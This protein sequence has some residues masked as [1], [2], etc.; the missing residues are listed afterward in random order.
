M[1]RW[2]TW[3]IHCT[4]TFALAEVAIV[5]HINSSNA[6]TEQAIRSESHLHTCIVTA[7][8]LLFTSDFTIIK[9]RGCTNHT[10]KTLMSIKM[11]YQLPNISC[12]VKHGAVLVHLTTSN[13][14]R[15]TNIKYRICKHS[16]DT[17]MKYNTQ[18]HIQTDGKCLLEVAN[19][20]K[21]TI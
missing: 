15:V 14:M 12:T 6:S 9:M 18:T 1:N 5:E 10:P 4:L 11:F 17:N 7:I 3:A 21:T 19:S 2:S 8:T 20:S 16:H 13:A